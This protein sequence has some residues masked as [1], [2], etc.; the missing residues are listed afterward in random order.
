MNVNA[1][2]ILTTA[3]ARTVDARA[4]AE[5]GLSGLELMAR[6][7]QAVADAVVANWPHL[8]SV[9]VVAGRGNNGGDG[10][11]VARLLR[12]RGLQVRVAAPLGL[13][14]VG[15]AHAAYL[16]YTESGGTVELA[17][18]V[19]AGSAQLIIDALLGTGL[20]RPIEGVALAAVRAMN[21]SA[22][23]ILAV[24][25]PS[26]LNTDT[27]QPQPEAVLAVQT[28]TFVAEKVGF[29]LG[30]G[31]D[32]VGLVQ[33][34]RLGIPRAA[35]DGEPPALRPISQELVAK[36]LP[37]RRRT[38][39]KGSH[40]RVVIVAGGPGMPGAALL[41]GEAALRSGAGLV[42][43]VTHPGHAAAI[44]MSRP[45]LICLGLDGGGSVR[46]V[47]ESADIVAIGPGLGRTAWARDL[48]QA[49]F[50]CPQPVV[51]D[52]DALN[53]LA[54]SPQR[55]ANWVLTPHPG[56]AGRL[57]G[58]SNR[59]IQM[60]RRAALSAL[61]ERYG[62]TVV[63]KGARTLVGAP[64][65]EVPWVCRAGN[66]GM[67]AAGMGDV[68]TGVIAALL[69]QQAPLQS[70]T[71]A[72]AAAVQVHGMAGD[73]SAYA[74]AYARERGLLASDVLSA[75]RSVVNP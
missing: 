45:E 33:V 58:C 35:Y 70:I 23:P 3:G 53:L 11:I 62:A 17:E 18:M 40:G 67:A 63:L 28:L 14:Q 66:P 42:T 61:V 29:H 25:T 5:F 31:P 9:L 65:L 2:P 54:E 32:F 10:Y 69:A 30:E 7:G 34:D 21:A 64:E 15:D 38:A 16:A 44:A 22:C 52:A 57:L 51:V 72:V 73:Y 47:F 19:N 50:D 60:D 12:R 27:G 20:A 4:I 75:L 37:R 1:F 59:D 74:Q 39:H 55:R 43:V 13:P 24:D 46:A 26:G 71:E 6:A 41:A 48:F 8:R 56:E 68:L 49:A 36:T